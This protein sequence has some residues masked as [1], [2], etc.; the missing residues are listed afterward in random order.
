MTRG[1]QVPRLSNNLVYGEDVINIFK[2]LYGYSHLYLYSTVVLEDLDTVILG[3]MYLV[4]GS[5]KLRPS[6]VSPTFLRLS[7]RGF[8]DRWF[9]RGGNI[10]LSAHHPSQLSFPR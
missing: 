7:G 9:I 2:I 10:L 1:A 8:H 3:F 6:S 5:Q 4:P